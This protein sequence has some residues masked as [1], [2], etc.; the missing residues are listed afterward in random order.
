MQKDPKTCSKI[1]TVSIKKSKFFS[2]R[3]TFQMANGEF[4]GNQVL[5]RLFGWMTVE[6]NF[7]GKTP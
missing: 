1:K 4:R 5:S 6:E 7:D 3:T 2:F